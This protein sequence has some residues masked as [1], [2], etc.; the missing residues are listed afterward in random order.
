MKT[1]GWQQ[2]EPTCAARRAV[3]T[4]CAELGANRVWI[5]GHAEAVA[6]QGFGGNGFDA[7]RTAPRRGEW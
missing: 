3:P 6:V 2:D 1:V 7:W 4:H 5:D